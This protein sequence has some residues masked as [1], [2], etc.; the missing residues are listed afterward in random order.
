MEY[1]VDGRTMGEVLEDQLFDIQ[2]LHFKSMKYLPI[3]NDF[4]IILTW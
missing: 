3:N 1:C 2:K 4:K